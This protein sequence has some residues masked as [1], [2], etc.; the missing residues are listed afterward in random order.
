MI[1]ITTEHTQIPSKNE[2]KNFQK[3]IEQRNKKRD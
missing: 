3:L 2:K 1:V